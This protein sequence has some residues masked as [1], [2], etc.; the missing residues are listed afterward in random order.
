MLGYVL[1]LEIDDPFFP[2][3]VGGLSSYAAYSIPADIQQSFELSMHFVP[4]SMD[5]ISLMMY[6]GHDAAS[7]H[8]ALSFIKGFIV[9]TWNLGAGPRRIF[10][11]RPIN[12][13]SNKA[14]EVKLGRNGK[15]A[16]LAVDNFPNIT[17][18]SVGRLTQLNT[19]P[20]LYLGRFQDFNDDNGE[21]Q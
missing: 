18:H 13:Q 4:N 12:F 8:V 14:H 7:D 3:S 2:G 1:D 9:L 20:V 6:V 21:I 17:G 5:Q 10:T 19:N 11:P 16:W 15:T